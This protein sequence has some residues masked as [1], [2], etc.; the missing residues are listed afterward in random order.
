MLIRILGPVEIESKPGFSQQF[1]AGEFV[2]IPGGLAYDA[3]QQG[4]AAP[5]TIAEAVAAAVPAPIE[6]NPESGPGAPQPRAKTQK[7]KKEN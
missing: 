2:D 4:A 6:P 5:A 1:A 7:P 3:I